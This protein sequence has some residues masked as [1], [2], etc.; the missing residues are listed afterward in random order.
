MCKQMKM[1]SD[2][3]YFNGEFRCESENLSSKVKRNRKKKN[4]LII[5]IK[6]DYFI[7]LFISFEI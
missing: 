4:S 3:K 2:K 6:K 1:E 7:Y 5:S